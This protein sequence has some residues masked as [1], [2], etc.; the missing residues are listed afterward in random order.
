MA[1]AEDVIVDAARHATIYAR[2]LWQRY[3]QPTQQAAPVSLADVAPRLDLLVSALTGSG[4]RLRVAQ[5]PAAPSFLSL[6]M[7]RRHGPVHRC[8]LPATDGEA[9]WLPA[10]LGQLDASSAWLRYRALALQQA[11]RAMRGS[12][13]HAPDAR[14]AL[15]RDVYLLC[16]ADAA[17]RAL[18]RALP[19]TAHAL[20]ALRHVALAA[21]PSPATLPAVLRPLEALLQR[22]LGADLTTTAH[23]TRERGAPADSLLRARKLAAALRDAA[24]SQ[25]FGPHP[26]LKDLWTG[27]LIAAV[28]HR[29]AAAAGAGM[30]DP[31]AHDAPRSARLV[32][33]PD[34]R[35]AD[36]DEDDERPGAWM[37]Q[38]AQPHEQAEDPHGLQRPTDRDNDTAAEEYADALSELPEARL[39]TRPGRPKEILLSDDPPTP[40]AHAP[41]PAST[42]DDDALAYPEWDYRID[43]YHPRGVTVHCLPAAEGLQSWV[44]TTLQAHR[45]ML[46]DIRRRF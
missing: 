23:A 8:A 4:L 22:T 17:D 44:D 30:A 34:V 26:L 28:P 43:A 41:M 42:P 14:D 29:V 7:R 32:R 9:I 12:A 20:A 25:H 45:G 38:T 3:R 6:A 18:A 10:N 33:R 21:R 24:P 11:M 40:A 39:L 27:E 37:V 31:S 36:D 35:E 5:A 15:L 46:Q 2:A 19:G 13:A 1:E 16:E